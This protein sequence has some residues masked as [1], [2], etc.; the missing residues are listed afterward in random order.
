MCQQAYYYGKDPLGNQPI[1]CSD[2][3]TASNPCYTLRHD[4]GYSSAEKE[5][6]R[7][8]EVSILP[9]AHTLRF[10]AGFHAG[11]LQANAKSINANHSDQSNGLHDANS[12]Q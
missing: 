5:I 8:H 4:A 9:A 7:C 1:Q 12:N 10:E 11:W 3:D 2:I 6:V